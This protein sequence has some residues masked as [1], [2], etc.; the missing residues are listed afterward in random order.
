MRIKLKTLSKKLK[1]YNK[2]ENKKLEKETKKRKKFLFSMQMI[3][4]K[5]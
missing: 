2:R 4:C 1:E 5:H 3:Y